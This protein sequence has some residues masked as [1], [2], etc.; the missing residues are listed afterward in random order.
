VLVAEGSRTVRTRPLRVLVVEDHEILRSGL[1]WV[2]TRVPWVERCVGARDGDEALTLAEGLAFDVALVDADLGDECG[3][4]S[5]RSS[6]R[7]ST[8]RC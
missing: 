4:H 7:G 1:R 8:P 3:L 2:L 5:A 6:G